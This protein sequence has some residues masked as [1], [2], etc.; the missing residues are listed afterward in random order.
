MPESR[1]DTRVDGLK[2]HIDAV[3]TETQAGLD[4]TRAEL[5]AS[6]QAGQATMTRFLVIVAGVIIA[7][8]ALMIGILR[9]FPGDVAAM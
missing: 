4:T 2:V 1:L 7:A 9:F 6:I 8:N 3:R 5:Q